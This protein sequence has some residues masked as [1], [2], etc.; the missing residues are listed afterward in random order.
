MNERTS[1]FLMANLGAEVSR[2]ISAK[3]RGD[4]VLMQGALK[5]A[6]H[7]LAEIKALPDMQP[8]IT[9]IEMLSSAIHSLAAPVAEF[10][11]TTKGIK[12]YFTPFALRTMATRIVG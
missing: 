12:S 11:I 7:I 3:E 10:T 4:V 8:R 2:L 6:E 9:E 1:L 5:R